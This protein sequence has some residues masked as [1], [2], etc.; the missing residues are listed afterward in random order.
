[1]AL[2]R[3]RER[4]PE[5]LLSR[6]EPDERP[7]SW[8]DAAGETVVLASSLGLWWPFPQGPRRVPWQLVDKVVWRDGIITVTEA[9]VVDDLLLVDRPPVSARLE[10]PRDL[11]PVVRRRVENNIVRREL[12]QVTGGA[13]RIVA[14]RRPGRDGAAWWARLEPGTPDTERLRAAIRARIELLRAES[15][16]E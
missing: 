12:L 1:M 5:S 6:L 13:V 8:A 16:Q 10:K 7:V 14:R 4:P 2:F 9:E 3:R 11:P 15:E